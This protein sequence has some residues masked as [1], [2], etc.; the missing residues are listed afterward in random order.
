[1]NQKRACRYRFYPTHE[2]AAVLA[3]TF[4][5][6]RAVD[7]W[8]L[9]LRADAYHARHERLGYQ[10]ASPALTTLKQQ[11]ETAWL[12]EV[13]SV[14]LQQALRHP[15]QALRNFF[16]G[17]AR[18]PTFK[19]KHGRQTATYASSAV[20]WDAATRALILAK[21]AGPLDVRWSRP[22]TAMPSN[23]TVSKDTA[24]RYFVSFLAQEESEAL[25]VV[26]AMVG[27]DMVLKEL[28]VFSTGEKSPIQNFCARARASWRMRNA[29]WRVNRKGPR[30]VTR[31]A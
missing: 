7:N 12:N 25:P 23:I 5:C 15:D 17:H 22:F 18:Y 29:P 13:S 3:R 26:N 4:G 14:P 8:G 10:Q 1:M 20:T 21:I 31:H 28:A 6:A 16:T 27:I 2:Q 19:E 30:I 9:R 11:P 24:G